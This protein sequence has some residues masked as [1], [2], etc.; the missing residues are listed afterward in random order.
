M[1][2]AAAF[3]ATKVRIN[4]TVFEL[5][6][7]QLV[8]AARFLAVKWKWSEARVRRFLERL[9]IECMIDALATSE[10]TLITICNYDQYQLGRRAGDA[11]IDEPAT[12]R[13]RKEEELEEKKERDADTRARPF[14]AP[15]EDV[16]VAEE[17]QPVIAP[18]PPRSSI[19]AEAIA[20]ANEFCVA[21]RVDPQNPELDGMSGAP[22]SAAMWL[23]RGY[24]RAMML[25]TAADVAARAWPD[26]LP[27]V[28]Y[29][30]AMESSHKKRQHRRNQREMPLFPGGSSNVQHIDSRRANEA[31]RDPIITGMANL[32]A[33]LGLDR[34][35][36]ESE[37]EI[38]DPSVGLAG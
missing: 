1:I 6:R 32:A 9:K 30:R 7:G 33:R 22:Y 25:A 10:A 24:D 29:N 21:I 18:P 11:K 37:G 17:Q 3:E 38:S 31:W 14:A 4:R 12:S 13:R 5:Q 36:E 35:P 19:T 23:E 8:Y 20:F 34:E 16:P 28:Y 15:I 2:G 26:R 27:L